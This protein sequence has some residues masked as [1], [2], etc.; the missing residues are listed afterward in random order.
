MEKYKVY[1]DNALTELQSARVSRHPINRHWPG[2]QRS[3]DQTKETAFLSFNI[4]IKKRLELNVIFT[5]KI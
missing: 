4:K 3:L 1:I 5:L 2:F